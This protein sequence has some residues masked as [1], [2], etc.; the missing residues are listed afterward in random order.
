MSLRQLSM[1]PY[2]LLG[3]LQG[4][5]SL[6]AGGVV[7]QHV[8]PVLHKP[9]PWNGVSPDP[10]ADLHVPWPLLHDCPAPP[11]GPLPD[12]ESGSHEKPLLQ[13]P[14][15]MEH[16]CPFGHWLLPKLL[17]QQ[18]GRS[19]PPPLPPGSSVPGGQHH[20]SLLPP[21]DS[22][23]GSPLGSKPLLLQYSGV[24][25]HCGHTPPELPPPPPPPPPPPLP[26]SSIQQRKLEGP[27]RTI[28]SPPS[29]SQI[30]P[31]VTLSSHLSLSG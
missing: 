8:N 20:C 1:L 17:S 9:G 13:L 11:P 10:H 29:W 5:S 27:K 7:P 14:F 22:P 23:W 24:A 28:L 21:H 6:G 18:P 3:L 12:P 19:A 31:V 25:H 4:S 26:P 15:E 2:N 16:V 30:A